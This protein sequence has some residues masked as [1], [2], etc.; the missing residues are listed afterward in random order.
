M[1][2]IFLEEI[3][4]LVFFKEIYFYCNLIFLQIKSI[5]KWYNH[6][7]YI[8]GSLNKFLDF[9]RMSTFIDSTHMKL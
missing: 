1:K 2:I 9:F 5:Q 3:I 4:S 8:Q 7:I 6:L